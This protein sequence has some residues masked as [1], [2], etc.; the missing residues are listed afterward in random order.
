M[1]QLSASFLSLKPFYHE[2]VSLSIRI[3]KGLHFCKP[4]CPHSV[5]NGQPFP[6]AG[7]SGLMAY[8]QPL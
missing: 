2:A 6:R 1:S 3:K 4:F 7:L 5:C 8:C